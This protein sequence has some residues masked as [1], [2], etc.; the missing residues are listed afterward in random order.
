MMRKSL[1]VL[2][3]L[4]LFSI[5]AAQ[6]TAQDSSGAWSVTGDAGFPRPVRI[7]GSFI[8][9]GSSTGTACSTGFSNQCPSG[10]SCSCLTVMDARFSGSRF[11]SGRANLFLTIDHTATFGALGHDCVP[12][13]GQIDAI[14]KDSP[15]FDLWGAECTEPSGDFAANGAMGLADSTLF[16]VSG[17]ATFTSTISKTGRVVLRFSGAAQ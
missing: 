15:T 1:L 5:L 6:A 11:G 10:D 12:I 14:A 9:T 8:G 2:S 7:A 16:S 17:Y 13:Y 3:I 4:G